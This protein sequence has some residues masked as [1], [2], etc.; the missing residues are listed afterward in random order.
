MASID[1]QLLTVLLPVLIRG[2]LGLIVNNAYIGGGAAAV[3]LGWIAVQTQETF[4]LGAWMLLLLLM[5]LA[6]GRKMAEL[7]LGDTA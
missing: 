2:I 1:F 4:T 5:A 6:T 3:L 7:T